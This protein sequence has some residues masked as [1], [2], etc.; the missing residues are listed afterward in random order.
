MAEALIA[1]TNSGPVRGRRREGPTGSTF[2]S[3]EN[4][5]YAQ[6]PVGELRFKVSEAVFCVL[7]HDCELHMYYDVVVITCVQ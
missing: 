2:Y 6:A 4:I 3:F 7:A 5:P 1:Q